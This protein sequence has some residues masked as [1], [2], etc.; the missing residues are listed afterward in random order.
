MLS[1]TT[2]QIVS[3]SF[4]CRP[5][6]WVVAQLVEHRTVTAAREGSSPFSPP[7]T[8][9]VDDCQLAIGNLRKFHSL[10]VVSITIGSVSKNQS[11]IGNR[12]LSM[13]RNCGRE[14]RHLVVN[15]ADDGSSPFSSAMR[16]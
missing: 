14:V 1:V 13:F 2:N 15:Q 16:Q 5:C 9:P 6:V 4:T 11:A 10:V 3:R 12:K 8:F 7:K